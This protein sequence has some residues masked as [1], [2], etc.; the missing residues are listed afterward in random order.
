MKAV[1]PLVTNLSDGPLL[2]SA[3][4][5]IVLPDL[6][7]KVGRTAYIYVADELGVDSTP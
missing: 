6:F 1:L 5:Q 7:Q 4:F 2:R 3:I